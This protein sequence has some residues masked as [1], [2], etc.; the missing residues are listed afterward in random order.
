MA[1]ARVKADIA[2]RNAQIANEETAHRI[3][4]SPI[5]PSPKVIIS[6]YCRDRTETSASTKFTLRN[7]RTLKLGRLLFF[8]K[9][10]AEII[11]L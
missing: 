3:F 7:I 9:F 6:V 11:I 2:I 4:I 8:A 10:T 1:F 5:I